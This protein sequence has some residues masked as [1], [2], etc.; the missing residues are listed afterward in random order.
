MVWPASKHWIFAKIG[1]RDTSMGEGCAVRC[2]GVT[3]VWALGTHV[4]GQFRGQA[5]T[6][7]VLLA[8]MAYRFLSSM[9]PKV[10]K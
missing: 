1:S 7:S 8:G 3:V 5:G 4:V 2:E 9:L 6:L 10:F